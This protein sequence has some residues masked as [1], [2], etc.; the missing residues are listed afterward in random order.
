MAVS[1][2][3]GYGLFFLPLLEKS[4]WEDKSG[5]LL[6]FQRHAPPENEMEERVM[7]SY[8]IMVGN[9]K[10]PVSEEVYKAYYKLREHELYLEKKARKREIPFSYYLH[11][12]F[13]IERVAAPATESIVDR[14]IDRLFVEEL[15]DRLGRISEFDKRLLF[16]LFVLDSTEMELARKLNL[17]RAVIRK[18]RDRILRNLREFI[19]F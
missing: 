1:R 4:P 10:C 7:K 3:T 8:F 6:R 9:T 13:D 19:V 17:S 18:R 11:N 2:R 5:L 12:G 16:E 15:L 14:I